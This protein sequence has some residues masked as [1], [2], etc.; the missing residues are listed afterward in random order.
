MCTCKIRIV[1]AR[2]MCCRTFSLYL[3]HNLLSSWRVGTEPHIENWSSFVYYYVQY[4]HVKNL[5][6]LY[7][8]AVGH[9]FGNNIHHFSTGKNYPFISYLFTL[10]AN[11]DVFSQIIRYRF[12]RLFFCLTQMYVALR[13][14]YKDFQLYIKSGAL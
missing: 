2:V 13:N 11:W 4:R 5:L 14:N 10:L 3:W 12:E 7:Y 1:L 6:Q 9:S 8:T